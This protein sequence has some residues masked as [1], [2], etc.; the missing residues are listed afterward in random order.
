MS[1]V[2]PTF[3][4]VPGRNDRGQ[5]VF[6]VIVKRTFR[7]GADG[8]VE[9]AERDRELLRIDQY[10]E[11]GDPDWSTVQY[12]SEL[13][14]YK[15][16][17]DLVVIGKAHAPGGRPTQQMAVSVTVGSR[18]KSLLITGDRRCSHREGAVP[19]FTDPA[20]F[21]QLEI[22]YLRAYGGRDERSMPEI[23][24]MYPRNF[25]GNGVVLRNVAEVVEGLALPNVEDPQDLL[26]PERLLIED[27]ARWHL[28]PLPQGLG[29]RQKTWYPRSALLGVYP[30]F[31]A[32]GTVTAEERMGLVPRNHIALAKQSDRKSVV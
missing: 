19:V 14:P 4:V 13:A 9:R 24:F 8:T 25:M 20:P 3:A 21:T 16:S 32:P 11:D 23:P 28:Q 29:W 18:R 12:E 17:T 26:T 7:I 31:T 6:S 2:T 30:A 15:P 22:N 5:H 27:P 1:A 10:Y